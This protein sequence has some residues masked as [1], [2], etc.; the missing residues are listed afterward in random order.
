MVRMYMDKEGNTLE[1]SKVVCFEIIKVVLLG[2]SLERLV[3]Q[4]SLFLRSLQSHPYHQ[5]HQYQPFPPFRQYPPFLRLG[6]QRLIGNNSFGHKR[7]CLTRRST[8]LLSVAG[9]CAKKS[10]SA[11]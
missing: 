5:S 6:G 10:R 7:R 8:S 9:R 1:F 11:G 2:L 4:Y 3:V